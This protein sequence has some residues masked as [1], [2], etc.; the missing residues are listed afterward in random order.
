MPH[1]LH[2]F[3]EYSMPQL[4][5]ALVVSDYTQRL[6][7]SNNIFI[8]L[9][10]I[11]MKWCDQHVISMLQWVYRTHSK[12][13]LVIN[14]VDKNKTRLGTNKTQKL[15]QCLS[16]NCSNLLQMVGY[17]RVEIIMNLEKDINDV[18][19]D[20]TFESY[21]NCRGQH[22]SR[23]RSDMFEAQAKRNDRSLIM[24]S[25]QKKFQE[26]IYVNFSGKKDS[27]LQGYK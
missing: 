1:Q 26:K 16:I 7:Y 17:I 19:Q 9:W 13:L 25:S 24:T 15:A 27:N 6:A 2:R 10:Q 3:A 4:V 14:L 21:Y 18:T 22:H 20:K 12:N 5:N 11:W 23:P 8:C